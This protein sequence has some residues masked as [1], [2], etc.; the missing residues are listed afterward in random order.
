MS[1]RN[2]TSNERAF[3]KN[4]RSFL[5][6][7]ENTP[8]QVVVDNGVLKEPTVIQIDPKTLAFSAT[9]GTP[10]PPSVTVTRASTGPVKRIDPDEK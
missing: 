2:L 9:D 4:P 10:L 6:D 7:S 5:K 8:I 3:R 1:R